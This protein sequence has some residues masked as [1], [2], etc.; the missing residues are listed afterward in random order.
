MVGDFFLENSLSAVDFLGFKP[1]VA[2]FSESNLQQSFT[3][4]YYTLQQ[5]SCEIFV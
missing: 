3:T 1:T 5:L 2:F 4:R